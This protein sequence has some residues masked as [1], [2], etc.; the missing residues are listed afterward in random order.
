MLRVTKS[1]PCPICGHTDWCGLSDDESMAICMRRPE[2]SVGVAAN[3]G[4]IHI[5]R[6]GIRNGKRVYEILPPAQDRWPEAEYYHQHAVTR[7]Y[8][9][10]LAQ[11]LGVSTES[12]TRLSVGWKG[13]EPGGG[14]WTF[15]VTN[16]NELTCGI[17]RRWADGTKRLMAGHRAGVYWPDG[18]Q[19]SDIKIVCEGASDTAY[20]LDLGFHAVGRFSCAGGLADVQTALNPCPFVEE[21]VAII[22]DRGVYHETHGSLVL[23]EYLTKCW[24]DVRIVWPPG[25]AKDVRAWHPTRDE[26]MYHIQ[27]TSELITGGAL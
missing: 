14:C 5:L 22:T 6:P 27:H 24:R 8:L 7:G 15:P 20:L 26:L 3:D 16:Q 18:P 12:L 17:V 2:G 10:I 25:G 19:F 11:Q 4:F 23:A 9:P 13:D 21:T 1:R